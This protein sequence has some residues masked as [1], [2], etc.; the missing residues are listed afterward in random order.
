MVMREIRSLIVA[1]CLQSGERIALLP[2]RGPGGIVSS[3]SSVPDPIVRRCRGDR[4]GS[5]CDGAKLTSKTNGAAR[6]R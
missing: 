6:Y 5:L 2:S 4:G 1:L 3:S